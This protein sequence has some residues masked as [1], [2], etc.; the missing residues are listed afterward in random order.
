VDQTVRKERP[1][2]QAGEGVV[3][4][5]VGELVFERLALGEVLDHEPHLQKG[6]GP[7]ADGVDE[8]LEPARP[9]SARHVSSDKGEAVTA[10]SALHSS[11]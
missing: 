8:R 6:A 2:G 5:P 11:R 9:V 3:E 1:V 7:V 10:P 4:G